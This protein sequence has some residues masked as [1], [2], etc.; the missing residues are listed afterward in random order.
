MKEKLMIYCDTYAIKHELRIKDIILIFCTNKKYFTLC[1]IL[2][3]IMF[4]L[5]LY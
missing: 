3:S 5:Q 2:L 1:Y 4:P